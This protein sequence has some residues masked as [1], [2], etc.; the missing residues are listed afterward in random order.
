MRSGRAVPVLHNPPLEDL[1]P[2]L[3]RGLL[4]HVGMAIDERIHQRVQL[5]LDVS[6]IVKGRVIEAMAG[7]LS[8]G[9]MRVRTAEPLR[10]GTRVRVRMQLPALPTVSTMD[11]V[12][13]WSDGPLMGL[14]FASLR[15]AEV[16]AI[17]RLLSKQEREKP[18]SGRV[19]SVEFVV[20]DVTESM[21]AA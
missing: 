12:V 5:V 21:G 6:L 8:T 17:H 4:T 1:R 14:Q 7:D 16:W 10:H 15:P 11:A 18:Q 20:S 3:A 13:R 9:G 2:A 19:P